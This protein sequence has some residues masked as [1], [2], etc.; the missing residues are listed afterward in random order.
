VALLKG[1][2][3]KFLLGIQIDKWPQV[4]LDSFYFVL[5]F[6]LYPATFNLFQA[7]KQKNFS[8]YL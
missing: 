5:Y 3:V 4:R 8:S 2:K 7:L 6:S 1:P